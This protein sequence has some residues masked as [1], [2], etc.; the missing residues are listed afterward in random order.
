MTSRRFLRTRCCTRLNLET[1][2]SVDSLDKQ[3]ERAY[4]QYSDR[5]DDIHRNSFLQS[6]KGTIY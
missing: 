2:D 1:N 3:L 5:Q 6:L 4:Q